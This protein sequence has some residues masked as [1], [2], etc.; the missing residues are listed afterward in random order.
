MLDL[1]NLFGANRFMAILRGAASAEKAVEQANTAWD[2][3]IEL[4]EIPIGE[5]S[6][7]GYLAAVVEAGHRRGKVVGAGTVITATHVAMAAAAGAR[8]TVA[9]GFDPAVREASR[10]AGLPHLPGVAT[11]SEVQQAWVAGCEWVKVFPASTLGPQWFSAIKGPFPRMR[12]LA[13]GGVSLDAAA[14]Y[15]DAGAD[16]VAFG[17]SAFKPDRTDDL[18]ALLEKYR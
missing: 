18:V 3:G 1:T 5:K 17:A 9:P 13:T 16:I 7:V 8:Y 4:V 12:Y 14:G 10:S 15:L 6:E 2:L 11:P